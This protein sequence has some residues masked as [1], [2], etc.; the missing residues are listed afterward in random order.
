[1][2]P[3]GARAGQRKPGGGVIDVVVSGGAGRMGQTVCAAVEGAEDMELVAR[4]DPAL[5]VELGSVLSEADVVVDFSTPDTAP[6]TVRACLA[7]GV[8][9]VVGTTGFDLDALREVVE[10]DGGEARCFVAPNFAI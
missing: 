7:Q 8:H 2:L 10:S 1:M 9:A 4:A 3:Q 6:E 5:G